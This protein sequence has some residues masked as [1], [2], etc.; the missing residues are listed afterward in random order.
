MVRVRVVDADDT[1]YLLTGAGYLKVPC[2]GGS[3]F[4]FVNCFYTLQIPVT[5]LLPD[6]IAKAMGCTVCSTLNS[7]LI[8]ASATM[9]LIDLF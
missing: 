2:C 9:Q 7:D 1:V 6:S 4:I 5:I 8:D 3:D